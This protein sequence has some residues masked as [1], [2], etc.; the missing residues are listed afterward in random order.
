M[1]K[2]QFRFDRRRC[3]AVAVDAVWDRDQ[4]NSE[5]EYC[6]V[7]SIWDGINSCLRRRGQLLE[8]GGHS[9]NSQYPGLP[10]LVWVLTT[11][12]KKIAYFSMIMQLKPAYGHLDDVRASNI[13]L[14]YHQQNLGMGPNP[15]WIL[16]ILVVSAKLDEFSDILQIALD[17]RKLK[18]LGLKIYE[19]SSNLV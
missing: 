8:R 12:V 17:F 15:P 9:W 19:N 10:R 18:K 16:R 13:T 1:Q 6:G 4:A 2:I 7:S 5:I 3:F 11:T 14:G